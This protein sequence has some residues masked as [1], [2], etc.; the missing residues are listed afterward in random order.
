MDRMDELINSWQLNR[1]FNEFWEDKNDSI[2]RIY[3]N[4]QNQL[5]DTFF[6]GYQVGYENGHFDGI[7]DAKL[8]M[9]VKLAVHKNFDDNT[10]LKVLE[11]ENEKDYVKALN[12]IRQKQMNF[13]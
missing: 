3:E 8:K 11:K 6:T 7:T 5:R 9:M 12:E 1:A 13:Y 2:N 4:I 10:I